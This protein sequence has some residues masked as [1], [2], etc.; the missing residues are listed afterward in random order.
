MFLSKLIHRSGYA[1][2]STYKIALFFKKTTRIKLKLAPS[3]G[4]YPKELILDNESIHKKVNEVKGRIVI[5]PIDTSIFESWIRDINKGF[6]NKS[7]V[8]PI[9]NTGM[10]M[11]QKSNLKLNDTCEL[12]K[13]IIHQFKELRK[14]EQ[15]YSYDSD[16]VHTNKHLACKTEVSFLKKSA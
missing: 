10:E 11:V 14:M 9:S 4:L 3:T 12:D 8:L 5:S 2:N 1:E 13:K 6:N 7:K 16:K 15:I